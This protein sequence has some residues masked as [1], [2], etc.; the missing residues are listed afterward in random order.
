MDRGYKTNIKPLLIEDSLPVIQ[1]F[2]GSG[3][4][5]RQLLC[6]TC[7]ADMK[8]FSYKIIDNTVWKCV[9]RECPKFYCPQSIRQG[10]IFSSIQKLLKLTVYVEF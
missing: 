6:D 3:L 1:F 10:S 4:I 7:Q 9:S 2:Q 5:K 8:M